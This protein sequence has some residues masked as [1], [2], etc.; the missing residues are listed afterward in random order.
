MSCAQDADIRSEHH[1]V[2]NLHQTTVKNRKT[3]LVSVEVITNE[4]VAA[5]VDI[6][7]RLNTAVLAKRAK[8]LLEDFGAL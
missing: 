4:N 3:R 5:I 6:Q 2:T 7:R 8:E 1:S